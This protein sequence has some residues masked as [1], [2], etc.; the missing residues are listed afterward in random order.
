MHKYGCKN[1]GTDMMAH[2]DLSYYALNE[3]LD[4]VQ[5]NHYETA[6]ELP[7]TAFSYDFLRCVKDKPFWVTETQVGWNGGAISECGYRPMGNSYAN[8]MLPIARGAEMNEYWLFR[9]HPNGHEI[10][11]G[12]LYSAAGRPYRVSEE[13]AQ[14]AQDIEK[15]NEFFKNTVVKSKIALHYSSTSAAS[16][17]AACMSA[18]LWVASTTEPFEAVRSVQM[19]TVRSLSVA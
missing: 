10:A 4:V 8:T 3:K 1:V 6:A 11:H 9:A 7:N 12:A 13:I 5:F 15:C 14:A 16:F 18:M 2:N 19:S 17:A